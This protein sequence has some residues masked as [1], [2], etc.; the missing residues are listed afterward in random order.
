V[1]FS[2]FTPV[3]NTPLQHNPPGEPLRAH[4][5]YQ[6]DFLLRQYGFG[7]DDLVFDPAGNLPLA[8]DPKMAWARLYL[9][10]TP[11]EVNTAERAQLLRIPGIGPKLA[12]SI[13]RER[14]RG[15]LRDLTDL[16]K[17]G[18]ALHR[19]APFVL[20]DGKRPPYQLSL[21]PE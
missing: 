8:I 3:F 2:T 21:W 19:A 5:L 18:V 13:L 20:L 11:I 9:A 10:H 7:F 14:Q 17:L 12:D 1:Y 4:R 6:S 15:K 16:R